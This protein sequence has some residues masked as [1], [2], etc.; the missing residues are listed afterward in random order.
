M[1]RPSGGALYHWRAYRNRHAWRGFTEALAA[2]LDE[3][4]CPREE[5]I[6]IGPSGGYTLPTAWLKTFSQITAYDL[7]PLAP[8]FFRRRHRG[9]KARFHRQ[10]MFWESSSLS[11]APL[12][13]ELAHRPQAA[14]LF[15]NILGQLLVEGNASESDWLAFLRDLRRTLAG[16]AWASYH[17]TFTHESGEIIDH[18]LAGDWKQGLETREFR[19]PLTQRSLHIIE[20]VRQP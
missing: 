6:L 19:W 14:V 18:L 7:D 13:E 8:L 17:D 16:R 11:L 5:L 4:K 12:R 10:D 15:S 2:W 1:I 20:A 3:W 9:V